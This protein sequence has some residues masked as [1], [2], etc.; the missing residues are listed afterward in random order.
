MT[1]ERLNLDEYITC[2][3]DCSLRFLEALAMNGFAVKSR[4]D[5]CGKPKHKRIILEL[6]NGDKVTSQCGFED[7]VRQSIRIINIYI[8]F[9]R[10]N[11]AWE[12]LGV[13]EGKPEE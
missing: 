11:R 1:H 3:N 4:V 5:D 2:K 8:G 9:A 13:I 7:E 10:K 12:K 6:F